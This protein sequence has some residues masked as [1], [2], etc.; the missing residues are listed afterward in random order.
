MIGYASNCAAQI[1]RE[2]Q[3]VFQYK[4]S[5][6][7]RHSFLYFPDDKPYGAEH[8]DDF[9][10]LFVNR[11]YVPQFT[12]NDSESEI[13]ERIT[14]FVANFCKNGDPNYDRNQIEWKKNKSGD[15]FY[16][17]IGNT[18]ELKQNLFRDRYSIWEKLFPLK[19]FKEIK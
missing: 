14:G 19:D 13:I 17:E 1:F 3:P 16:V 11:K 5:Y 6:V 15:E 4:F 18:C 7:G 12:E 2:Y 9:I 10:Y 8:C